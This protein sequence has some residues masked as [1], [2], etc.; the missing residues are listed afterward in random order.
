MKQRSTQELDRSDPAVRRFLEEAGVIER[1]VSIRLVGPTP[2]SV[3]R[4]LDRLQGFYGDAIQLT[5]ARQDDKKRVW[6]AY[7]TII[8]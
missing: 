4:E 3:Q 6:V 8:R 7:G 5:Q 2:G 1:P